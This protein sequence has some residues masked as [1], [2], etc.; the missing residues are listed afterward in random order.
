MVNSCMLEGIDIE[1]IAK[2]VISASRISGASSAREDGDFKC[3]SA[4]SINKRTDRP[5]G[6][7]YPFHNVISQNLQT[8]AAFYLKGLSR[9]QLNASCVPLCLSNVPLRL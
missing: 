9:C 1:Q 3:A 5:F 2:V 6:I 4:V 7:F 8:T